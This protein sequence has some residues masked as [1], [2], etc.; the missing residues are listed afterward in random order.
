MAIKQTLVCDGRLP[1]GAVCGTELRSSAD[2]VTV[3]GSVVPVGHKR[4]AGIETADDTLA[5]CWTCFDRHLERPAPEPKIVEKIVYRT[6]HVYDEPTHHYQSSGGATGPLPPPE[7]PAESSGR[8][9]HVTA[10]MRGIAGV[11]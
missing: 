8:V 9:G 3:I 6:E 2:G 7:L 10:V 1:D 11:R 4:G 5:F